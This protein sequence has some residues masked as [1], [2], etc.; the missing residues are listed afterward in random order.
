MLK[1]KVILLA[2]V[3]GLILFS[4][5]MSGDTRRP[6]RL[7]VAGLHQLSLEIVML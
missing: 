1:R 4:F 6:A 5:V 7:P 3:L 2:V